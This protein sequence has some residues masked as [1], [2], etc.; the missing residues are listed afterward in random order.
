M[1]KFTDFRRVLDHAGS[2]PTPQSLSVEKNQYA[3]KFADAMAIF[4][5]NGLRKHFPGIKP[6]EHG[7]GVESPAQAV[8]GLKKLDVNFGT[9]QAG[10]G[11]GVSLKS[12]HVRDKK[13][14]SRFIHNMK[15]NDE[16]LRVEA[17]GYHQRQPFAVL[18]AIMV[19]P[20]EACH[21]GDFKRPSSFGKWV[22]YLW[23]LTGRNETRDAPERF[24]MVFVGLYDFETAELL[25]F[26]VRTPPPKEGRPASEKL[27]TFDQLVEEIVEFYNRRNG[28][29]FRW[30]P[31]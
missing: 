18:V 23:P 29:D 1:S 15:R 5:A 16:E 13:M 3:M 10:L 7:K 20:I 27:L 12:V 28:K 22:E 26:D 2:R 30:Q 6:D 31:D 21:D 25:F 9:P 19:L 11:L 14:T 17:T 24:E 4:V 8:R